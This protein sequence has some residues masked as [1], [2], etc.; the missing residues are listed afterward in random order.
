MKNPKWSNPKGKTLRYI[1][2]EKKVINGKT[3]SSYGSYINKKIPLKEAKNLKNE[4]WK[5]RVIKEGKW[6]TLYIRRK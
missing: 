6:H 2:R 3:Y 1:L 4:G 5:A